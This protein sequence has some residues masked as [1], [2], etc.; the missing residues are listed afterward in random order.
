MVDPDPTFESC[1]D[2]SEPALINVFASS[3]ICLQVARS[4]AAIA[5][6]IWV[7]LFNFS[8]VDEVNS[9]VDQA[10]TWLRAR[11][12]DACGPKTLYLP[13]APQDIPKTI[14]FRPTFCIR[15]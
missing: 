10:G 8:S 9:A 6:S 4:D 3:H 11:G 12:Y 15:G 2:R 5:G 13:Q 14:G 1:R 7:W